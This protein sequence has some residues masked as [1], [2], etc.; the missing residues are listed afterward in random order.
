ME[1]NNLLILGKIPHEGIEKKEKQIYF[2]VLDNVQSIALPDFE[3]ERIYLP[4]ICKKC[5]TTNLLVG[6]DVSSNKSEED[7]GMGIE[8]EHWCSIEGVC[9]HC[10]AELEAD[11]VIFE[12]PLAT[13][14]SFEVQCKNNCAPTYIG[15]LQV[16]IE[17]VIKLTKS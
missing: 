7:R 11:V 3:F 4:V 10:N 1:K 2:G 9:E 13:F 14:Q 12:Y 8:I 16:L 17:D 15:N 5:G 6:E